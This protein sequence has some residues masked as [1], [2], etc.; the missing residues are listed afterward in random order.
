MPD[1]SARRSIFEIH[2]KEK[3]V[4]E[5]IDLDQLASRTE[6]YNGADI[7][8]VCREAAAEAGREYINSVKIEDIPESV[9]NIRITQ[10]YF[11]MALEK[12]SPSVDER[13]IEFYED[14]KTRLGKR[15]DVVNEEDNEL[16][17]AFQ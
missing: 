8:A 10:E 11:D 6:G 4:S 13:V 1:E 17:M 12:I 7:A 16:S 2:T 9:G 15:L 14:M 3:P 5:D